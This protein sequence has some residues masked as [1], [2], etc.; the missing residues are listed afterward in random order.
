[1]V[2]VCVCVFVTSNRKGAV[3]FSVNEEAVHVHGDGGRLSLGGVVP[4]TV[5]LRREVEWAQL[6]HV[7][8]SACVRTDACAKITHGQVSTSVPL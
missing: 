2:R 6:R 3:I 8:V 1:M 5:V 7:R 4:G